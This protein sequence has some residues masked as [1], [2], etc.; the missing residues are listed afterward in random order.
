MNEQH[1]SY[2]KALL[3]KQYFIHF[4]KLVCLSSSVFLLSCSSNFQT[5][6]GSK[7]LTSKTDFPRLASWNGEFP[8]GILLEDCLDNPNVN[9]CIPYKDPVSSIEK[10]FSPRLSFNNSTDNLENQYLVYGLNVP[11][12]G[13]L[14]NSHFEISPP[15]NIA[16]PDSGSWKF[17]YSNDP[18]RQ[19]AQISTFY[20]ANRMRSHFFKETG[21]FH[22]DGSALKIYTYLPSEVASYNGTS[23]AL[24]AINE[25]DQQGPSDVALDSTV[26]LHEI[27]HANLHKAMDVVWDINTDQNGSS[28]NGDAFCDTKNGCFRAIHEAIS[29]LHVLIFFNDAGTIGNF[30]SNTL[31]GHRNFEAAETATSLF[32]SSNGEIHFVGKAYAAAWWNV[33]R[34]NQTNIEIK[35][36]IESLFMDHLT[37][38]TNSDTFTTLL[39]KINTILQNNFSTH[40]QKIIDDF[41]TEYQALDI[42]LPSGI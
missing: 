26:S 9:L 25:A 40:H 6:E 27:G 16:S 34:K 38:V 18:D 10:A 15:V 4:L 3:L 7:D 42:N 5:S 39:N 11:E 33:F 30:F 17:S 22:L 41:K 14:V 20:W 23:V 29:D 2:L 32:N 13:N 24:G 1:K 21:G 12:T 37:V 35:N 8:A 28:S 19:L 31:D 36:I